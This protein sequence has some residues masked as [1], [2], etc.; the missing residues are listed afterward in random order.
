[1]Y[2]AQYGGFDPID[3]AIRY[4]GRLPL[5]HV[6]DMSAGDNPTDVPVGE[7]VLPWDRILSAC[8][9]AGAQ[10]YIVEMDNPRDSIEDVRT[11]LRNLEA[12]PDPQPV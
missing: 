10:W 9:Q 3:L 1:M 11:S 8:A 2:W 7:G 6:K 5:I 4:S 12:M